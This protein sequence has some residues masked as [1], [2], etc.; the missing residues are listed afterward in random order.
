MNQAKI[1]G[2]IWFALLLLIFIGVSYFSFTPKPKIYPD[3]VTTSPSPTGVKA[4]YTYLEKEKG[5]KS[6]NH[7]PALL[8]K[9]N[10]NQML[11]MVGPAFTPEKE[12]MQAYVDYMKA[13]NTI[14]LFQTNPKGMFNIDADFIEKDSSQNEISTTV[15]DQHR[16]LYKAEVNSDVRIRPMKGD[17]LLLS[18][19][20]GPIA[21]N[22]SF[23]KGH[24]IVAIT[25]EWLTNAKLLKKD[26][27]PLSFELLNEGKPD[28]VLFDEYTHVGEN[29]ATLLTV[30]PMGFLVLIFQGIL[31]LLLW[32]WYKG[33]RFGPL[34]SEREEWVRFSDEGIQAIAAWYVKG[35]R[36]Q[37]S[38]HIQADYVKLLLQER[39]HVPY[40]KE[41]QDL[42]PYVE[43]KWLKMPVR[44]LKSFLTG[45]ADILNQ[46]K[47]NK[48][49]YLLWSRKLEELRNEVE[50]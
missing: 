28:T 27:L 18:D 46:E 31:L 43:R 44:E 25:P 14:V 34:L 30:Y 9:G 22:R 39:W 42:T 8:P 41:W 24:L 16:K 4:L 33:K 6:W 3:Y 2:S 23:G 5:G 21:V 11:I 10:Q 19:L 45:L 7:S 20:S 38:L 40:S 35:R 1:R 36:Y 48:Q 26:H 37:D 17:Q 12:M 49:E 29:E 47:I 32:L 13:G 15:K 50:S